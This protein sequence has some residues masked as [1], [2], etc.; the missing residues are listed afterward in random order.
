MLDRHAL[1][2]L[3]LVASPVMIA[4]MSCAPAARGATRS[5]SRPLTPMSRHV[6]ANQ[7]RRAGVVT[8]WDALRAIAPLQWSSLRSGPTRR[9]E[10]ASGSGLIGMPAPRVILD[11]F[12]L[13]D[14][15][16]LRAMP[17]EELISIDLVGA[18]DA[19]MLFG[20]SYGGG[21][22]VIRTQRVA[23]VLGTQ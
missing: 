8:A 6:D 10:M 13:V 19:V 17:A 7:I 11:G 20:Q 1:L 5:A 2:G 12:P 22:I 15:G 3:L 21:A 16:V 4:A 18:L 9:P 14:L 23:R